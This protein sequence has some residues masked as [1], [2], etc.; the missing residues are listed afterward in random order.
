MNALDELIRH[1]HN[2][3]WHLVIDALL[4]SPDLATARDS[5]G[6]HAIT[7]FAWLGDP[8]VLDLLL[9]HGADPNSRHDDGVTPL[10]ACVYGFRDGRSTL[11]GMRFL[12]AH[13]ADPNLRHTVGQTALH[14]AI[15]SLAFEHVEMMLSHGGDPTL[16]VDDITPESGLEIARQTKSQKMIALLDSWR[17][18]D[19]Q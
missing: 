18:R 15:R 13:G 11:G 9:K 16:Q 3:Q 1:G 12:L 6:R 8:N 10:V 7:A 14:I 17:G 4:R 5:T 19:R 2:G